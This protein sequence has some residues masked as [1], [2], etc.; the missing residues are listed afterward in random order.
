MVKPYGQ[1]NLQK[2][3]FIRIL[4]NDQKLL[5][6]LYYKDNK[7]DIFEQKDLTGKEKKYIKDN[8]IFEYKKVPAI[9]SEDV[10]T[11]IS[12][13]FG[14]TRYY[15]RSRNKY[16]VEPS[17]IVYLITNNHL[18][19]CYNGSRLL[20]L[21]ERIVDLFHYEHYLS[22]GASVVVASEAIECPYPF[23][24]RQISIKFVDRNEKEWTKN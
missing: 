13:E 5:K 9:N 1:L 14:N 12:M 19:D 6:L 3:E 4:M 2:E 15:N 24:G 18:D 17:I 7:V 23:V 16:F 10:E 11:Y 21:E 8:N 20:S 22:I